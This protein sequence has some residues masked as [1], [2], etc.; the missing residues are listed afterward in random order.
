MSICQIYKWYTCFIMTQRFTDKTNIR[1][2]W[3]VQRRHAHWGHRLGESALPWWFC[4]CVYI[5]VRLE[6]AMKLQTPASAHTKA[7]GSLLPI[8]KEPGK[9]NLVK[10]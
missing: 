7:S 2:L 4:F 10:P 8:T 1:R 6:V 3:K 5:L 9:R